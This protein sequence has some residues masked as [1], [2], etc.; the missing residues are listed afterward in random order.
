MHTP[1]PDTL[2]SPHWYRIQGLHPSLRAHVQARLHRTRGR[3][4]C[5]LHNQATGRFHRVNAQ[6]Y[7][8]VGRLDG[9]FT[10]DAI[11]QGLLARL[12]DLAPTQHDVI[13]ILGQLTEAGLVQAEVSPDVRQMLASDQQR[14]QRERRSRLNPLSFRIG[15]FNP[16]A[17]LNRLQPLQT[18]LWR[19]SVGLAWLALVL[20]ASLLAA[21]HL[22]ELT[23]HAHQHLMSPTF[24][25]M[26]WVLY[27]LMKAL[28]EL[29]HG[30]ALRQHGCEVPEMGV[31]FMLCVPLPYVDARAANRLV[32]RW[33]RVQISAA[34]MAVELALAS[35]ALGLWCLVE[36]GW[37]RELAFVTLTLGSLSTLVFNG[38]PLMKFDGYFIACD[39]LA[40][41]NLAQRSQQ[42][43]AQSW[44][45]RLL[46][47]LGVGAAESDTV[48][49]VH[50]AL[51]RWA[52]RLYAPA[53]WLYRLGVSS[54]L[55]GWAAEVSAWL[56]LA[57]LA[58]STWSLLL[59]PGLQWGRQLVQAPGFERVRG[60]FMALGS[61][62]AMGLLA[63]LA[64]VPWPSS[65]VVEGVVWLPEQAQVRAGSDADVDTQLVRSGQ[66]V[67]AGQALLTLRDPA[68]QTRRTVL[69]AQIDS[70]DN[71]LHGALATEPLRMK[72]AQDALARDRA[73]LARLD[74]ELA[75]LVLRAGVDGEFVLP[76]QAD[77]GERPVRRG[78]LLAYVLA[79]APSQVRAVVPQH[80]VDAVRE[81]LRGA[82]VVLDEQPAT[83][84]PAHLL[85]AM[86]AAI[87]RLPSPALAD[88]ASGRV[89]TLAPEPG[90][91]SPEVEAPRPAEPHFLIDLALDGRVPR[92]GGLARV[93]LELAP[94]ALLTT[95]LQA[96]RQLLLKH[97]AGLQA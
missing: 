28:H 11:W 6:A 61:A 40:L 94:Q 43:T 49:P 57:V 91:A 16:S 29:G 32:N 90:E 12:G 38:N 78:E 86:P 63:V 35:L 17:L 70:L 14:Q 77:L 81:R 83:V 92:S 82:T 8:L 88:R 34:G 73:E 69:A 33:E 95:A 41:P 9:R 79:D 67:Q 54:L 7:E 62:A 56:G 24:L 20:G 1:A 71:E 65:L 51:E 87:E 39:A 22:D 89:P 96:L 55:V 37:L 46:R 74:A 76:H 93:R 64:L 13:R 23:A 25:A 5:V 60:R 97:F 18:L 58:W 68:L 85:R 47:A 52:L 72:N 15:L 75:Q 45:G 2:L 53:S 80:A 19:R 36:D 48:Q 50:D 66:H 42:H 27:P 4:W 10:V 3:T 31:N 44:Q 84:W 21:L 26:A 59:A 30:L